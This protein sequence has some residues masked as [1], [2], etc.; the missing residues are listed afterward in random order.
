MDKKIENLKDYLKSLG[1]ALIAYSGGIDSS[2][3][4]MTAFRTLGKNTAA[5]TIRSPLVPK[6]EIEE[7]KAI[8]KFIG[9]E[10]H[11]IPL[12]ILS[13]PGFCKNPKNR[14]YLCKGK[15]FEKICRLSQ[16]LGFSCVIEGSNSDDIHSYRPGLEALKKMG[17]KSPLAELG[18]KKE[19]I[20]E[21]AKNMGLPNYC[22]PS[23]ACLAS[24][25]PYEQEITLKKLDMISEAECF[26][27]SLG[28]HTVRVR[29]HHSL[30]RIEVEKNKIETIFKNGNYKKICQYLKKL[31]FAYTTIDLE[32]FRSGSL[33]ENI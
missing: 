25:I 18:F 8:A 12:N 28:F 3:L 26:I 4:A 6:S 15:M 7:S 16:E 2:F 22:L 30:A 17:I 29:C 14:C 9:I 32:G 24:R 19:E 23:S 11:V 33:D 5:A 13:L 20:R 27:K 10:H 1:S 21:K 31:G